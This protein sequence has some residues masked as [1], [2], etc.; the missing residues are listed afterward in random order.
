MFTW[1]VTETT[2]ATYGWL[3]FGKRQVLWL[4]TYTER[5][6]NS[7][8][9]VNKDTPFIEKLRALDNI[10]LAID[11]KKEILGMNATEEADRFATFLR[12][13]KVLLVDNGL[14]AHIAD[15]FLHRAEFLGPPQNGRSDSETILVEVSRLRDEVAHLTEEVKEKKV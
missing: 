1:S 9:Y 14:D 12:F 13:E 7:L 2:N 15:E 5:V 4:D 10:D 3:G 11:P 8:E 6:L